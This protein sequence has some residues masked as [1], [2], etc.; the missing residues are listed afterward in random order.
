MT[1]EISGVRLSEYLKRDLKLK[2]STF[3]LFIFFLTSSSL[4]YDP[5]ILIDSLKAF[6]IKLSNTIDFVRILEEH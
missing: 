2:T 3:I 6:D 4:L 5:S 1:F